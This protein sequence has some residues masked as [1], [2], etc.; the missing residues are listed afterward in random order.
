MYQ[1]GTDEP[2]EDL[3]R[4]YMSATSSSD[5]RESSQVVLPS[6]TRDGAVDLKAIGGVRRRPP[7]E[8]T[9]VDV[10]R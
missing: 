5:D 4:T 9:R 2:S 10:T 6:I 7:V 8:V 3:V 1:K